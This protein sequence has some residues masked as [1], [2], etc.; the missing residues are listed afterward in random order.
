M[1]PDISAQIAQLPAFS[2]QQLLE[3]WQK[4]Y[5]RAAPPGIRRELMVPFLAYK[6]QENAYGRLKPSTRS[7]L[8][9]VA[10]DLEKSA[11]SPEM[12]IQ[13]KLKAGTRI[14]R[15][16]RGDTHEVVVT[17]AGYEYRGAGYHSLSEIARKITGARWSGPAFFR[18][19]GARTIQSG[20]DD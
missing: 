7:Q 16:W 12:K 18:L 19:H 14:F 5:R 9:Q 3:L 13:R 2:R 4:L 1:D 15:E 8:R 6:I 20:S 11:G 10:Q 17:G